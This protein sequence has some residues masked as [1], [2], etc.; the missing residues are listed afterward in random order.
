MVAIHCKTQLISHSSTM[1]L[2]TMIAEHL[3]TQLV[4]F[5]LTNYST[6]DH[7][8]NTLT[9]SISDLPTMGPKTMVAIHLHTNFLIT[10]CGLWSMIATHSTRKFVTRYSEV[11]PTS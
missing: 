6:M 2:Q 8:T 4:N 10:D 1:R 11:A 3:H 5:N 9:Q 7:S